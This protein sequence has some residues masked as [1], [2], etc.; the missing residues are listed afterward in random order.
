MASTDIYNTNVSIHNMNDYMGWI[1]QVEPLF[2]PLMLLVIWIVTFVATKSYSAS[3]A[4]TY[5][6]FLTFI[7]SVPLSIM[8]WSSPTYIY[9]TLIL[10][11]AGIAWI[12]LGDSTF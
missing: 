6:S 4:W 8:G 5:A 9:L 7:L 3:R 11:A 10:T 2:F 12:R 1:T